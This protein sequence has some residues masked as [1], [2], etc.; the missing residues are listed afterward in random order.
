MMTPITVQCGYELNHPQN[1]AGCGGTWRGSVPKKLSFW[2]T[3][4]KGQLL[5]EKDHQI[6]WVVRYLQRS[7]AQP[8][9]QTWSAM[10]SHQVAQG[11]TQVGH[12]TLQ[13]WR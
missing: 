3:H 9:P 6:F 11:F 1:L 8:S 4:G 13:G 10:G 2:M 12:K 5:D 7:P